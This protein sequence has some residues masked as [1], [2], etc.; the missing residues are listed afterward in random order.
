MK[1]RSLLAATALL[2]SSLVYA[3]MCPPLTSSSGSVCLVP[4]S[5][6]NVTSNVPLGSTTV[7]AVPYTMV[8]GTTQVYTSSMCPTPSNVSTIYPMPITATNACPTNVSADTACIVNQIS[9]LRGDVR[10][11]QGQVQASALELRGQQLVTR[12]NE[13]MASEMLF[14]Q[15]IAA[16]PNWPDAQNTAM[17]LSLQSDSL[18]RDL[19]AFNREIALIPVDQ[20]PYIATNLNTFTV[21]YWDPTVQRFNQ[22]SSQFPMTQTIYQPAFAANPWLQT[23]YTNYQ[24]SLNTLSTQPQVYA[25]N[26]WWTPGTTRVLGSTEVYMAP[27][28]MTVPAGGTVVILPPNAGVVTTGPSPA[29]MNT[30][31]SVTPA[32][33]GY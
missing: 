8:A 28:M 5:S 17:M 27:G 21:A 11:L 29:T 32:T 20:R 4:S 23:W 19:A 16:N 13:L 14:R 26:A 2:G 10:A 6:A 7:A 15:R 25:S 9:A 30:M 3:Q 33:N 18:N 24:T 22:Y 1:I 31:P 12:M